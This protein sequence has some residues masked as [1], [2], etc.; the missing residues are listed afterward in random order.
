MK[1]DLRMWLKFLDYPT[2]FNRKFLDFDHC[3]SSIKVDFYTDASKNP[4]LGI[5]GIC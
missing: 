2:V 1:G 3:R 4:Q 5:G